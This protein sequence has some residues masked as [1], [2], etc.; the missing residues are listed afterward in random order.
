MLLIEHRASHLYREDAFRQY[1]WNVDVYGAYEPASFIYLC[2]EAFK[3]LC[4]SY[5]LHLV[6]RT[7]QVARAWFPWRFEREEIPDPWEPQ[8]L[9]LRIQTEADSES[10]SRALRNGLNVIALVPSEFLFL[11]YPGDKTK[12]QE[13]QKAIAMLGVNADEWDFSLAGG[14]RTPVRWTEVPTDEP[15]RLFVTHDCF[16][17]D[18]YFLEGYGYSP[19]NEAQIRS[20]VRAFASYKTPRIRIMPRSAPTTWPTG[21]PLSVVVDVW[22]HGPTIAGSILV[23][24]VGPELEPLSPLERRLPTLQ[25]LQ[26]ATFSVQITPRVDGTFPLFRSA[27]CL[28]SDGSE[29]TA[30]LHRTIITVLP[31]H[32]L[33]RR[34]SVM[35][36]DPR[37][38][39]L[40][41]MLRRAGISADVIEVL[42]SL[43]Q[44]D[45]RAC[46]N[47]LRSVT[48]KILTRVFEQHDIVVRESTLATMIEELRRRRMVSNR[49]I[50]YLHTIRV[51]G[52][53]AS[54]ASDEPVDEVDVRI[55]S[56]ALACVIE[57]FIERKL[58]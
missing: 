40:V 12:I 58:L 57:E 46:A 53:I 54:H 9:I 55:I 25:T 16:L 23:L 18:G 13:A 45:S 42:P 2:F 24:D 41:G 56:Y 39:K 14:P 48:E 29:V 27:R 49:C 51:I 22:N 7:T 33:S 15:G 17:S 26:Q 8:G 35:Q 30:I 44:V 34:S 28:A 1:C 10:A 11:F 19:E 6:Y 31:G 36:D 47:R 37:L 38:R 43:M 21:E 20:L 50:S 5:G 3:D 32:G 4:A 52:N